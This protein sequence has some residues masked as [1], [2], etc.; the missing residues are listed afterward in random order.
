MQEVLLD[1]PIP[2]RRKDELVRRR[3]AAGGSTASLVPVP[4]E[5]DRAGVEAQRPSVMYHSPALDVDER[6][7]D[8]G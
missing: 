5:L 4:A 2:A 8:L 3:Q 7:A 1:S 6:E